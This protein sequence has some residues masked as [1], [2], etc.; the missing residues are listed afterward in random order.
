MISGMSHV[1]TVTGPIDPAEMGPTDAHEHLFLQTPAQPDD[2][3]DELDCAVTELQEGKLSGLRTVVELTPIGLGR[4]P[5]LLREAARAT[6][7]N[8]VAA[9]GYHRDAHYVPTDWVFE[10]SEDE[11][12]KRIVAETWTGVIKGGASLNGP[13]PAEERRLRA[14]AGAAIETGRAVIVHTEAGT[15][16]EKIVDLMSD[17]GLSPERLTLAHMD[18]NPD[19]D[20]HKRLLAGGT[21]LVYDTIGREKYGPDSARVELIAAMVEAGHRRGLMLGLDLGRRA[22]HRAYGGSPGM[23]HLMAT[24]APQLRQAIGDEAVNAM[25]IANPARVLAVDDA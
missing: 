9:S 1:M 15:G 23:R 8:I 21:N 25:L 3:M 2:T 16:S 10:A 13:T 24:F 7:M 14:V 22:Y 6:G 4:Q 11:L 17:A 12:A 20:L 19:R 5:E 18:R